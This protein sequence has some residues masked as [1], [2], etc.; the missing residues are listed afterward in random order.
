MPELKAW[1]AIY[2]AMGLILN[3]GYM[4]RGQFYVLY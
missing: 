4:P 3:T 1:A 2:S